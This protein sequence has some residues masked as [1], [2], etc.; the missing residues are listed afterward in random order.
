MT[1]LTFFGVALTAFGPALSLFIFTIARDPVRIII[2]I[3]SAFFW[4]VSL[5]LSSGLW[6]VVYPLRDVLAFG[7]F[8]SVFFQEMFRLLLYLLLRKADRVMRK[9][10]ENEHTQIFENKHILAY[11]VGLGF[12]MMA[13]VFSLVNILA[14]SL[15]PGTVGWKGESQSFFMVSASLSLA[16]ILCHTCWG[17]ITFAALDD[18]K[19]F[20]VALV[21]IS[22][23][24][25][26]GLTLFNVSGLYVASV[27]PAYINLLI[28]ATVAFH[29]AG[30]SIPRLL[31]CFSCQ[32]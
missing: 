13:G 14:D 10:T 22:H 27:I 20:W 26:S 23:F 18:G 2:L 5:L 31:K 28:S 32:S 7:L 3:L 1:A 12:G 9:L 16:L 21:W 25:F 4:L 19:Y 29:C 11:V 24:L 8:F 17:V 6:N 30:G 15:G